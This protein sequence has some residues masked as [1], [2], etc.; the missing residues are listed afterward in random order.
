[1][2]LKKTRNVQIHGA[3]IT[4]L[5]DFVTG[6]FPGVGTV[7]KTG[8]TTVYRVSGASDLLF[9]FVSSHYYRVPATVLRMFFGF[10]DGAVSLFPVSFPCCASMV[11]VSGGDRQPHFRTSTGRGAV[12]G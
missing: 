3:K 2:K 11:A 6:I 8:R 10:W 12:V 9:D 5:P 7:Q 1:M 4:R